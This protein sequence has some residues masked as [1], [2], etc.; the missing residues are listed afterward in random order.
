MLTIHVWPRRLKEFLL[1]H[2]LYKSPSKPPR[3]PPA[4]DRTGRAPRPSVPRAYLII[5]YMPAASSLQT[6]STPVPAKWASSM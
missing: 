3:L 2:P 6:V 5:R 4:A 1:T